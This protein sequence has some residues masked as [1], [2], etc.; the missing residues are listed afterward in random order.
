[1]FAQDCAGLMDALGI[2]RAHML[3]HSMGRAGAAMVCTGLS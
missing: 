2:K 1:M 3:G